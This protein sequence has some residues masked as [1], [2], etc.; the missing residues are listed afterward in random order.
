MH[1]V[2]VG[3]SVLVG[4]TVKY[5]GPVSSII[6]DVVDRFQD[7]MQRYG[8]TPPSEKLASFTSTSEGTRQRKARW[9]KIMSCERR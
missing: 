7:M 6:S 5:V 4:F 8:I 2:L 3:N 1:L 9:T